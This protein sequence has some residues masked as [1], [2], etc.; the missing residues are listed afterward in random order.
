MANRKTLISG[1][2]E[3]EISTPDKIAN[4][5]MLIDCLGLAYQTRFHYVDCGK[6][7]DETAGRC[8]A[9]GGRSE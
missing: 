4:L 5:L 1:L 3:G 2:Q 6:S 9:W 8:K 7:M